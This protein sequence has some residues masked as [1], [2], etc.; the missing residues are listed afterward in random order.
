M[1][2]RRTQQ[3]RYPENDLWEPIPGNKEIVPRPHE[4]RL[5]V[6]LASRHFH[7][8]SLK[9]HKRQKQKKTAFRSHRDSFL[10]SIQE[11]SCLLFLLERRLRLSLRTCRRSSVNGYIQSLLAT[12]KHKMLRALAYTELDYYTYSNAAI[13]CLFYVQIFL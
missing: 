4:N 9:S 10:F 3:R 13:C 7:T 11:S 1:R 8:L 12:R 6:S 2:E 5:F